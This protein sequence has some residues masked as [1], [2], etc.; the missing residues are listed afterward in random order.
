MPL[1]K[2]DTFVTL[3]QIEAGQTTIPAGTYVVSVR[4]IGGTMPCVIFGDMS[5]NEAITLSAKTVPQLQSVPSNHP[6]VIP[7]LN[8]IHLVGDGEV[9]N[10]DRPFQVGDIVAPVIRVHLGDDVCIPRS[11]PMRCVK[12]DESTA[13]FELTHPLTYTTTTLALGQAEAVYALA[14]IEK[15]DDDATLQSLFDLHCTFDTFYDENG[16]LDAWIGYFHDIMGTLRIVK[17]PDGK[18]VIEADE[19]LLASVAGCLR[20][21]AEAPKHSSPEREFDLTDDNAEAVLL[22]AEYRL[23]WLSQA[24]SFYEYVQY[25]HMGT[26]CSPV[27]FP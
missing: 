15:R 18:P 3:T 23:H 16:E 26:R 1:R 14:L 11:H 21:H 8:R 6:A 7:L 12:A 10:I 20:V 24:I 19:G 27:H 17:R 2:N 4:V 25:W 9:P 13:V 5:P 22:Y